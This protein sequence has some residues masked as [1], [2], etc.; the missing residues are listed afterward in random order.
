ML[1]LRNQ[2]DSSILHAPLDTI[3]R[4]GGGSV[5]CMLAEIFAPPPHITGVDLVSMLLA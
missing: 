3:E 1:Q 5:R 4:Y 2:H